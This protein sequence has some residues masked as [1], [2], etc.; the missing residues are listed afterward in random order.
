MKQLISALSLKLKRIWKCN[1]HFRQSLWLTP[2]N[3][4]LTKA[5]K[6]HRIFNPT[7]NRILITTQN[8]SVFFSDF[9]VAFPIQSVSGSFA[10]WFNADT[11]IL[12]CEPDSPKLFVFDMPRFAQR[13]CI[14]RWSL[15]ET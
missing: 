10:S 6:I 1:E 13:P 5:E 12:V 8:R 2:S 14:T 3:F 9:T 7:G 4:V 15:P 11:Q